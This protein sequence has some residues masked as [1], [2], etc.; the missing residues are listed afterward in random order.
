MHFSSS[1]CRA[2]T[3]TSKVSETS[4]LLSAPTHACK[5]HSLQLDSFHPLLL[6]FYQVSVFNPEV[7]IIERRGR[8]NQERAKRQKEE[9][10]Q[11]EHGL[12]PPTLTF[13]VL[14]K[15]AVA[16]AFLELCALVK[17]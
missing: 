16:W 10:L 6:G 2:H 3:I 12:L 14:V 5:T 15:D 13:V 9:G 17:L 8:K 1:C 4:Y 7:I 11:R